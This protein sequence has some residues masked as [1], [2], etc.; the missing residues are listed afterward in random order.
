[1]LGICIFL[2]RF[3]TTCDIGRVD[4]D[5]GDDEDGLMVRFW[6]DG[7]VGVRMRM[8]MAMG[9][10]MGM[11]MGMRM[12][13]L[14][15]GVVHGNRKLVGF[16]CFIAPLLLVTFSALAA[17]AAI[18]FSHFSL[19]W[20]HM[21]IQTYSTLR[22]RYVYL[23]LLCVS[24]CVFVRWKM[25]F[26][27]RS[28]CFVSFFLFGYFLV[29]LFEWLICWS[30]HLSLSSS[31]ALHSNNMRIVTSKFTFI[32]LLSANIKNSKVVLMMSIN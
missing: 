30:T 8:A 12:V 28:F 23:R 27:K 32:L 6:R 1:M 19:F 21:I 9:M 17:V 11:G 5:S 25:S 26:S 13:L 22:Y 24:V 4:G 15:S 10:G 18:W 3:E 31:F 2:V 20:Y 16:V 29:S 7:F 14:W